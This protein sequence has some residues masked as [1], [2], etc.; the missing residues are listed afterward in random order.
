MRKFD[1]IFVQC[2]LRS[3]IS[4]SGNVMRVVIVVVEIVQREMVEIVLSKLST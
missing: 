2:G 3:C 4:L 1:V